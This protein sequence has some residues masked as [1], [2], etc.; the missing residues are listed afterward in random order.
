M[1]YSLISNSN[2]IP[3]ID[4][5]VMR[6]LNP[7]HKLHRQA[8][9]KRF[10]KEVFS[11]LYSSG[12]EFDLTYLSVKLLNILKICLSSLYLRILVRSL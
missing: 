12:G 10:L 1:L 3:S 7:I 9:L 5:V 4:S 8:F 2:L 6:Q 11:W